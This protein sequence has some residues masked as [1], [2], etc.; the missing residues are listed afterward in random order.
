MVRSPASRVVSSPMSHMSL[1]VPPIDSFGSSLRYSSDC[2]SKTPIL[3]DHDSLHCMT[4][5]DESGGLLPTALI[6]FFYI[7]FKIC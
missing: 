2:R 3:L 6:Q 5:I 7:V 4:A 1:S